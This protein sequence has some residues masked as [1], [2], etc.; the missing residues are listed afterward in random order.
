MIWYNLLTST[1]VLKI[2]SIKICLCDVSKLLPR[3]TV[4]I[5]DLKPSEIWIA[6]LIGNPCE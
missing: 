6:V 5:D 2:K 1:V 3:P 4:I